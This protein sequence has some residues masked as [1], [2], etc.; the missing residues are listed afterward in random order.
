MSAGSGGQSS[1]TIQRFSY[2]SQTS[3][4]SNAS[5]ASFQTANG[6]EYQD[7]FD[8]PLEENDKISLNDDAKNTQQEVNN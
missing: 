3:T 5:C 6:G 7:C 2:K 1:S 4:T 8:I